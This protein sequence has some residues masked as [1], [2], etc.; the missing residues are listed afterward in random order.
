MGSTICVESRH[1][2]CDYNNNCNYDNQG[3]FGSKSNINYKEPIIIKFEDIYQ[4]K[5]CKRRRK[6]RKI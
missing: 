2:N 3:L 5:R 4:N 1:N 6:K